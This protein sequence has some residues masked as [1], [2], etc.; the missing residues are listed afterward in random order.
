MLG[1]SSPILCFISG[2]LIRSNGTGEYRGAFCNIY[3]FIVVSLAPFSPRFSGNDELALA[4]G[5]VAD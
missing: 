5:S 3:F 4:V 1:D 2:R